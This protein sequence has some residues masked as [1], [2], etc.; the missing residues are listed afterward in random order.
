MDVY[1]FGVILLELIL[2]KTPTKEMCEA[3][4]KI[5]FPDNCHLLLKDLIIGCLHNNPYH[6]PSF[7]LIVDRLDEVLTACLI[8]EEDQNLK[9][10]VNDV[11]AASF[12]KSNFSPK[13]SVSWQDFSTGFHNYFNISQSFG[14]LE[15]SLP[16]NFTH[17][18]LH[19]ATEWQLDDL[20]TR[21]QLHVSIAAAERKR[22]GNMNQL[23]RGVNNSNDSNISP[24]QRKMQCLKLIFCD[25]NNNTVSL[26]EFGRML[27]YFGPFSVDILDRSESI[28]SNRWFSHVI[29][30]ELTEKTLHPLKKNPGVFL[31]RLSRT[32]VGSFC[33]SYVNSNGQIFHRVIPYSNDGFKYSNQYFPSLNAVVD[34][35]LSINLISKPLSIS[36]C[37]FL[38]DNNM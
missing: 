4:S 6:R 38:F 9:T 18:Q 26:D 30:S 2:N 25:S 35:L 37:A 20:A 23:A 8:D 17:D 7:P 28:L 29:N 10:K 19:N 15:K 11:A 31:A 13:T 32:S 16:T 5:V 33:I 24:Y 21:S 3:P 12:W 27:K 34:H 14:E 36:K 22:R 1:S